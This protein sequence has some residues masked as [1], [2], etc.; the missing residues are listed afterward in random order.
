M[1]IAGTSALNMRMPALRCPY[2]FY[3]DGVPL[4]GQRVFEALPRPGQIFGIEVYASPSTIPLQF[5][6]F[7]PGGDGPRSGAYCG[8]ILVWTRRGGS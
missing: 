7:G 6:T 8:V 2:Q 3:L 1:T 5:K 4:S